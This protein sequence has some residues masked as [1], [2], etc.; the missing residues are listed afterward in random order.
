M[1]IINCK[2]QNL[3]NFFPNFSFCILQFSLFNDLYLTPFLAQY[4]CSDDG[5][6]EKDGDDLK[7][8]KILSEKQLADGLHIGVHL[9]RCIGTHLA[10]GRL[11]HHGKDDP[12]EKK[13]S[14]QATDHL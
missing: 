10:S 1:Q 13:N 4:D 11:R 6:N 14:Q 7:G 12:E 9:I 8:E 2:V 3:S 5:R